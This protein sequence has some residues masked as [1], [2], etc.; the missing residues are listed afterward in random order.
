MTYEDDYSAVSFVSGLFLG[1]AIGAGVA[2]LLAPQSGRRT[3][4]ALTRSMED[5]ADTAAERWEDVTD[6]LRSAVRSGRKKL[7]R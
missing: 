5:V 1:A 2:L 7:D 6:E 4:R 3:R